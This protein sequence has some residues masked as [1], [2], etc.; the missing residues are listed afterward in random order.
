MVINK[1]TQLCVSIA[2]RPGNFGTVIHNAAFKYCKLNFIYKAFSV[3]NLE[4]AIRG[5]KGFNIR[6]CGVSMPFKEA[7]IPFLDWIDPTALKIGAINTIVND[8]G[9]L[10]GYNTDVYGVTTSI[11][12]LNLNSNTT[13]LIKGAGGIAKAII[14]AL[15]NNGLQNIYISNRTRK[16]AELLAE[17]M[18]IHATELPISPTFLI[19]ATSVGM[20]PNNE[21]SIF[22]EEQI[23]RATFILDVPT[24]P[25]TTKLNKIATLYKKQFIPG[26]KISL[27]QAAKQFELYT[28][29]NAPLDVMQS[30]LKGLLNDKI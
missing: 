8:N 30:T 5:I 22:T 2:E 10:K 21:E 11:V 13:V 27:Y 17:E 16:K 3:T 18:S 24:N 12:N 14:F 9:Q 19:N 29:C 4:N 20:A 28:N 6:G 1:D 15:K 26:Y 7:V 25:I 23:K